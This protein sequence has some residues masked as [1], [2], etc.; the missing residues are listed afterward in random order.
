MPRS[1][2]SSYTSIYWKFTHVSV[3]NVHSHSNDS[4]TKIH[5]R[6]RNMSSRYYSLNK[7]LRNLPQVARI[8]NNKILKSRSPCVPALH[9]AFVWKSKASP[10]PAAVAPDQVE[11]GSRGGTSFWFSDQITPRL[12][13]HRK[14]VIWTYFSSI[15]KFEL[16]M[17]RKLNA[18]KLI[19]AHN[20]LICW[21]WSG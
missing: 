9:F 18:L 16:M 21:S 7:C 12:E 19:H 17:L 20:I 15:M 6:A 5:A 11:V 1:V 4:F 13:M 8:P 3:R 10:D 2:N 14:N